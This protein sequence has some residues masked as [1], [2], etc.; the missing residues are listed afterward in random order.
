MIASIYWDNVF[1]LFVG[2]II[3]AT[4]LAIIETPNSSVIS[5]HIINPHIEEEEANSNAQDDDV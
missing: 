2:P 3:F 5:P 4:V 1:L